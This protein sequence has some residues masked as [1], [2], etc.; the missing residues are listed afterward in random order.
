MEG[1][2]ETTIGSLRKKQFSF[3]EFFHKHCPYLFNWKSLFYFF[4]AL[5]FLGFFWMAYG[6]LSNSFTQFYPWTD[7][8]GQYVTMTYYFR[9]VWTKFWKTGYFE[10]YS[11][12]T[13]LGSDNIGSNSYYGLFDPFLWICYIFPRAWIPQTFAIATILKGCV[14]GFAMRAYLKYMGLSEF[15][16]RLGALSYAFNGYVNFMVGFPSFVSMSAIVPLVLLGIEQVIKEKKINLLAISLAILGFISFFFLVVI[17]IFGVL[18]A[19][20]R[21]FQTIKKRILKDQFVVLGLGVLAFA[22]GIMLSS[23]SLFP[24]L[25]ESSLSGRTTSIGKA[26]LDSLITAFGSADFNTIFARL[27]EMVGR[28]PARELQALIGFFYPTIGYQYSPLMGGNY[29]AWTASLFC[30]TPIVLLFFISFV[31]NLKEKKWSHLVAFILVLYLLFTNFAYFFFYAFTGDGY[32]RWYIVLMPIIIYYAVS[33]VDKLS[34]EKKWVIALGEGSALF[35]TILTWVL[36]VV[37]VRNHSFEDYLTT[38]W[39]KEYKVPAEYTYNGIV[40]TFLWVVYLQIALV[41]IQGIAIL[42]LRKKKVL[43]PFLMSAVILETILWG[44]VSFIV[45]DPWRVN[46]LVNDKGQIIAY[47]WNGGNAYREMA[48][49]GNTAIKELDPNSYYRTFLEGN[50]EN[51]AAMAFGSNGTSTFHSLFNYDVNS[52][53]L[54]LYANRPSTHSKTLAYGED[55]Y[56]RSWSAYYGNKRLGADF[57]LGIKYYGVLNEGYPKEIEEASTNLPWNHELVYGDNK[58]RLRFYKNKDLDKVS[59]G[60]AVDKIYKQ[61]ITEKETG[62]D[63]FFS[64]SGVRE[65]LRNDEVLFE[66]AIVQDKDLEA[67]NQEIK[68]T[69]YVIENAYQDSQFLASNRLSY[70]KVSYITNYDWWGPLNEKGERLGPTYFLKDDSKIEKNIFTFNNFTYIPD[71]EIVCLLPSSGTYFNDD[72]NGAYFA[73]NYPVSGTDTAKYYKTRIYLIGDTF[74]E[75]GTL[76]EEN[77]LLSYDYETMATYLKRRMI[78][79]SCVYGF[80]PKGRVKAICFNAKSSDFS[81][82]NK[83]PVAKMSTPT[84]YM[85]NRSVYENYLERFSSND[86]YSLKNVIYD[87]NKFTFNTNFS[88]KRLVVTSIGYDEG[89]RLLAKSNNEEFNLPIFK[90]NGGFVGFFGKE[91]DVSYEL[92]YLTPYLKEAGII[93]GIAIFT[94]GA[95][96]IGVFVYLV[97][98]KKK[99]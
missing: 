21:Y 5:F 99:N 28:H 70:K 84:I 13:Y 61:G 82:E 12:S 79:D 17:C 6:L 29:D 80:Y 74:N 68:G 14:S 20:F 49:K 44:N 15:S 40:R 98:K 46:D 11:P 90:I 89:W 7:Y 65:I 41:F 58:T 52:L 50:P 51:N 45:Y 69:T 67:I 93:T 27:F 72:I 19:T 53:S 87:K 8:F 75:D 64:Y 24:S 77:A 78:S 97:K 34:K 88:S 86:E 43:K 71:Q 35:L 81:G 31:S 94:L 95:I 48:E 57:A 54:Y 76:K 42:F 37:V 2:N 91:G 56:G 85:N 10:L 63:S 47:G 59:L 32:G 30:Y 1:G 55:Y 96:N 39:Q 25:R 23:I 9:D 22:L 62:Y 26:Y 83:K 36:V 73:I 33:E 38:Y 16:A 66:G 18:Y 92:S 60:H 3:G 4:W